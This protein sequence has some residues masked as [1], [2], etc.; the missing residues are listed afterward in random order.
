VVGVGDQG[1]DNVD[2]G[3]LSVEGVGVVD[4]ELLLLVLA[5]ASMK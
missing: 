4:I 3:D 1:D 5:C 2:F